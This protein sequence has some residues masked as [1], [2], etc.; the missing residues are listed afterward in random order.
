MKGVSFSRDCHY[1][2][3]TESLP[4]QV[5]A[6]PTRL[7]HITRDLR[8][9][10]CLLENQ[11]FGWKRIL[12]AFPNQFNIKKTCSFD[13][14]IFNHYDMT[15]KLLKKYFQ[16]LNIS[17]NTL[18]SIFLNFP[19]D[20]TYHY[21]C[22]L[23]ILTSSTNEIFSSFHFLRLHPVFRFHFLVVDNLMPKRYLL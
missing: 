10:L 23:W 2:V 8:E 20:T 14:K 3:Q 13:F 18:F 22:S 7:L 15:H 19:Y 21:D 16:L 1:T 4:N 9:V 6:L 11:I 5:N 12:L 17:F